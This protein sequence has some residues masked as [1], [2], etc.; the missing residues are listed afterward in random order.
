MVKS[1]RTDTVLERGKLFYF[2]RIVKAFYL[3]TVRL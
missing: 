1:A 2:F 3:T